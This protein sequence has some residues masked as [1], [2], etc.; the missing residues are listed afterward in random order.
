M[1]GGR[2]S[3]DFDLHRLPL[4]SYSRPQKQESGDK[5]RDPPHHGRGCA[6]PLCRLTT[7]SDHLKD[8]GTGNA[9]WGDGAGL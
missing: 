1:Q 6:D 2:R 8:G 4:S 9:G 3:P 7:N 5:H